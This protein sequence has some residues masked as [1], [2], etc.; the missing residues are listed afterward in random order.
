M[1]RNKLILIA[2]VFAFAKSAFVLAEPY[3]YPAQGQSAEQMEKDK[4]QCYGWG[5]QQTGYD[6]MNPPA[7]SVG[8][9][10]TGRVA[11]GAARGAAGGAII[12]AIAGDA[13]KGAAIGA[14]T[15]TAT[16]GI[17][18]RQAVGQQQQQAQQQSAAIAQM[19]GEYDRAY[20]VCLEG[21][22]YSVK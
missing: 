13:G 10:N 19:R 5:K 1:Y 20:A 9:A 3:I 16:R 7:V 4:Y 14:V 6:P 21:R 8:Q 2:A 11:G 22:G 18:N 12:G 15:G 17:R